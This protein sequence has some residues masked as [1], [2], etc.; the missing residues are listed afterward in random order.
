MDN[1]SNKIAY[2]KG[3]A[4]GMKLTE[5]SDEGLMIVKL[6]DA[7]AEATEEISVLKE[8]AADLNDETTSLRMDM[9]E[10]YSLMDA[11]D[12]VYDFSQDDDEYDEYYDD[13]DDLFD[14]DEDNLFEIMCPECGEDV[15]VDFDMLDDENNIVCP[16]CHSDI[17]LEFDVEDD[18]D[19]D[20]EEND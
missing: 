4:D 8:R 2:L 18:D 19:E 11:E 3:L 9:D 5:K 13:E 7:M 10:L 15:I 12:D 20:S 1:L 16:N 17:E 6:L 14:D